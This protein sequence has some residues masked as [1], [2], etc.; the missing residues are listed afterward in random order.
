MSCRRLAAL[1]IVITLAHAHAVFA[2]NTYYVAPATSG[3]PNGSITSPF[4]SFSTAI[5]TAAPGDTIYVRGGTYNLSSTISIGSSKNGTAANPYNML[6]YPGE[7]PILDFRGETYSASN[8]GQKGISISGSYWHIKGLTV[9]YAADNGVSI[10]GS[11]NTVEQVV[12]R[13]NQDSGFIISGSNQ[14]SNNLLLNCDSYGNFD[15]G[16]IG[17]N[18][19]GFAV[20]FRGL[21]PGNVISGARSYDNGDDGFDFWQAEHGVTVTNSWSFHNGVA[22]SFSSPVG[23]TGDG[24]GIK[25]GHDSGTHALSN[26]LVWGNPANGVDINGNATQLE[27]DPPTI[28]HGVTIYNVTSAMNGK[29]FQFDENPTTAAPPTAHILRNN[30]SYSGSTTIVTGNTADHNTFAGPSGSP[31]GLGAATADFISTTVPVTT[32]SSFHPAGTGGDR[33]GTTT[34]VYATGAAVGPRQSDGSLPSIDFLKLAPGSHLI[35]AGVNVGL[36]FNGVA[37]DVGWFESG[38]PAP[39]LPG[40]YNGDGSVGTA[41]YLVWRTSNNTSVTLP[42]DVSPG[43]VDDSDYAVWRSHFGTSLGG[44][45]VSS[46]L[47]AVPEPSAA[48]SLALVA[49][50]LAASRTAFRSATYAARRTVCPKMAS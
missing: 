45:G 47:T 46:D 24:N 49:I 32:W 48:F 7:T 40:D 31:A 37:P 36:P 21:G 3:T 22:S 5:S 17:E 27:P 9:Q 26:M 14:P 20:K 6:A 39:A 38:T 33:S 10:A 30:V 23:F 18:A 44:S 34:P 28:P 42:N 1:A 8:A 4:T 16:T 11:N 41:D 50:L 12:A 19:D 43:I 15:Y 29:N 13:Q 25:L 2:A 35:D